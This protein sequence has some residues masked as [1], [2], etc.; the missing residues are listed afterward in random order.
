MLA[1]KGHFFPNY[2]F[3]TLI[4]FYL[5][6]I[7]INTN[8]IFLIGIFSSKYS[9][10]LSLKYHFRLDQFF[11]IIKTLNPKPYPMCDPSNIVQMGS[12]LGSPFNQHPIWGWHYGLMSTLFPTLNSKPYP[13]LEP[14]NIVQMGSNFNMIFT[15]EMWGYAT[16]LFMI[17]CVICEYFCNY[18]P[19]SSNLGRTC[20][21]TVINVQLLFFPSSYVKVSRITF[22]HE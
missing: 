17:T 12:N 13:M 11:L 15:R 21:F 18:I 22:I 14:S 4:L 9:V 6:L 7:H 10:I 19:T 2:F 16:I 3:F 8:N 5:Y 1:P 20:D